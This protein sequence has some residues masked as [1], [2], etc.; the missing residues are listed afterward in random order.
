MSGELRPA[1]WE[2]RTRKERLTRYVA[3]LA[4]IVLFIICWQALNIRYEFVATAPREVQDLF[5]RMYPPDMAYSGEV[6][7]PLIETVHIAVLGTFFATLLSIPV[8]YL[9]AENT[10]PSRLTYLIGRL[11]V[12]VTRSVSVIIWA[13]LFVLMFG[14]GFLAGVLAVSIRSIGFIGK[15]L[16]EAVE[17]IDPIQVR[18]MTATGAG[19]VQRLIFGVVPQVKPAFVG[20]VTYR[21]DMNVRS[22]TVIGFVGAGGIGLE[23]VS[24]L[25]TFRWDAVLT[26]LIAILGIVIFSEA[27]SAYS[28][29]KVS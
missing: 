14:P 6:L 9:A 3:V 11:I 22:S 18:A 4:T 29:K 17:E 12:T 7:G 27:L 16:A 26:I 1:S 24:M 13:L 21:W 19:G 23:L 28:R 5:V 20:I 8:A 2:R 10:T 15:L 25:D